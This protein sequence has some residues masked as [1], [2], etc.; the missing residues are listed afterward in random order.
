MGLFLFTIFTYKKVLVLYLLIKVIMANGKFINIRYPFSD[1]EKGFFLE[2]NDTDNDAVKSDLLHLLL[3]R[4]GQRLYKPDFGTDLLKFIFEPEDGM[5]LNG[6]KG[7][8][9]STV[10][11][12]MPQLKLDELTIEESP[13]NEYAAVLTIKYTITDA[14]FTSSDVIVIKL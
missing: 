2:L 6:V 1:S 11:K 5:T 7:E 14:V 12:Y 10:K 9:F 13:E 8:V 4:R 3:T